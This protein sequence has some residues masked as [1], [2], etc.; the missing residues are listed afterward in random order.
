M[1]ACP[2]VLAVDDAREIA[3]GTM[4]RLRLAGYDSEAACDER[5]RIISLDAVARFFLTRPYP[6][7]DLLE[8]VTAAIQE[9]TTVAHD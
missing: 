9:L 2:K 3:L 4:L 1:H 8:A 7:T 5:E 6:S